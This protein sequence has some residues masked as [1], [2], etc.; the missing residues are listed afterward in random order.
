MKTIINFK[1]I[2]SSSSDALNMIPDIV[3]YGLSFLFIRP[4]TEKILSDL[5]KGTIFS[6]PI[7]SKSFP[8]CLHFT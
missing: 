2:Y 6:D 7:V 1:K 8:E 5:C 4:Y 3:G